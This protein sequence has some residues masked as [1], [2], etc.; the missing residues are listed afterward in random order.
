MEGFWD[1][2]LSSLPFTVAFLYNRKEYKYSQ[3]SGC[4]RSIGIRE[5][6]TYMG[7]AGR[8]APHRR[9]HLSVG[10]QSPVRTWLRLAIVAALAMLSLGIGGDFYVHMR[11]QALP[12]RI[13]QIS[14]GYSHTLALASDGTVYAWGEGANGRLGNGGTSDSTTPVA[15][16][17]AGTP[18]AGKTIIAVKAGDSHSLAL[19]SDGTVYAWGFNDDG[20]LGNGNT[21][22][23]NVPVA[24]TMSGVLAGKTVVAIGSGY[25]HS[26]AITSD[27]MAYSWGYGADGRLGN[28]STSNSNV[29]VAVNMSGVLAGKK[30]TA[31]D[32]G[33]AHTLALTSD[34]MAYSW[35]YGADGRLGNNSTS[36]SSVP[37]AVNTSGV[38]SG[39]KI[40]AIAPGEAHSI[41]LADDGKVYSWGYNGRGQL[42]RGNTS[43]S[44]V[45]VAVT[46]ASGVLLNKTVVAIGSGH[47]HSHA[48]TSDGLAYSWGEG[49]DGRLGRGSTAD[50]TSPVAVT[51]SGALSG[52]AVMSIVAGDAHSVALASDGSLYSWGNGANGRLGRGSTASSNVP[53]AVSLT[54][55]GTPSSPNNITT[56]PGDGS[57]TLTWK[58]PITT[59]NQAITGYSLQY[60]VIGSSIW[61]TTAIPG[62]VATYTKTGLT[63]NTK[64]QVRLA[65]VTSA[66][67]G[68]YSN[69]LLSNPRPN[70]TITSVA[71][72]VGPISGGQNV[73]IVGTGFVPKEKNIIQLSVSGMYSLALSSD[74][75]VYAWGDGSSGQ[76]GNNSTSSSS[77]PVAVTTAGTPMAGKTIVSISAGSAHSLALASDGTVYGWGFNSSGQLG[78]NSTSSSSV[79]VAVTTAG[80]PMAGKTIVS[81]SAGSA[82]SLALAS[83]GT[84]Y[85]WGANAL[86]QLG[87]GATSNSSL[88]VAVTMSGALS[89]KTIVQLSAGGAHS[90]ALA[91]NGTMYSWGTNTIGQLGN[92]ATSNS[93]LPVAVTMSG[94]LSG[95]TI[96]QLSAGGSHSLAL[97][98]DGTAYAWGYG[99][100]G[101]LGVGSV[102]D[103]DVPLAVTASGALN[104]VV[105]T[106]VSAGTSHSSALSSDGLVYAWGYNYSGQLGNNSTTSYSVPVATS[107]DS[108]SALAS[109][110]STVAFDR[111]AATNVTR[112]SSTTITATTPAHSIGMVDVAADLGD[113]DPLYMVTKTGAYSYATVPGAP[114]GLTATPLDGGVQLNWV[115]PASSG[116]TAVTDYVIQYS[117]D[118]GGSWSTYADGTST[119][120]TTTVPTPS[121]LNAATTYLF[122]AAA[123]NIIGQGAYSTTATGR[124]RYITVSAP[125]SATL[126]ITPATSSRM[127]STSHDVSVSTNGPSGYILALSMINTSRNITKGASVIS[128]SSGTQALPVTLGGSA[129][130][131]RVDGI[132]GFGN[133]PTNIEA[134]VTSSAY[135][136]AGV[137]ASTAPATI[138]TYALPVTGQITKVWYGIS[139]NTTQESG[140][141]SGQVVYTA[142]TNP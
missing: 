18:M 44:S 52:K 103:A 89:G 28:N 115:T 46:T 102:S 101:Q 24:V 108:P 23:S 73:T 85:A 29:P 135:T 49:T 106:Q 31:I 72:S 79:P 9:R 107:T 74:G 117:S 136:W 90:L 22:S 53:V 19:A 125:S 71:P 78:N 62:D 34:G 140:T 94:A 55:V 129:W 69:I 139:A 77:V 59:Y 119:S 26:L 114:T 35:G 3:W 111:L 41:A 81:I 82:H 50:A 45:P 137:P 87:N 96:V 11:V 30:I 123:V 118:G 131:Y 84:A 5:R 58:A 116:G 104:N 7:R 20:E 4:T 113:G 33:D 80:T 124:V 60:R 132:G 43:S 51:S 63:N 32:G 91:S 16:T 93:S 141:Y 121:P 133:G 47:Y 40:T 88:P 99:Y 120:T 112:V 37:V 92:G 17:T 2:G 48:V 138:R 27:G 105:L 130:G 57:I 15:V 134:N 65:A 109:S 110:V 70:P 36:S 122:R 21:T 56:A 61:T 67:T 39:K 66:G 14:S 76:L 68:D 25:Y 86:G 142:T 98:S 128:P 42:G 10:V 83:D 126:N 75:V 127:S 13:I 64:Y 100:Y 38:L 8:F 97:A 54:L 6:G 12:K 95:K 1:S